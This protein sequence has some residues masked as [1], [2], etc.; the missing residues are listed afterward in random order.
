MVAAATLKQ[1]WTQ[2]G[3]VCESCLTMCRTLV[4]LMFVYRAAV[5]GSGAIRRHWWKMYYVQYVVVHVAT[6]QHC[7]HVLNVCIP[8]SSDWKWGDGTTLVEDVL[9]AEHCSACCYITTLHS[10]A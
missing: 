1:H 6:L 10:C 9:R 4:C 2:H 7:T 3:R 5:T 8:S